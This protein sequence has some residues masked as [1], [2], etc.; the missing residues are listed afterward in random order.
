MPFTLLSLA[1]RQGSGTVDYDSYT[2]SIGYDGATALCGDYTITFD[3]T[4]ALSLCSHVAFST[5]FT[6]NP[7]SES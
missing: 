4:Q 2:D 7:T 6:C 5:S 3:A 1:V